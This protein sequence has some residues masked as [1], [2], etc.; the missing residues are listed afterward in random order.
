MRTRPTVSILLPFPG[1]VVILTC[2]LVKAFV[3]LGDPRN[4]RGTPVHA[5]SSTKDGVSFFSKSTNTRKSIKCDFFSY[6]SVC[7]LK[8]AA[9]TRLAL[10]GRTVMPTIPSVT[11]ESQLKLTSDMYQNILTTSLASSRAS[12]RSS[13]RTLLSQARARRRIANY[14]PETL[15]EKCQQ[16]SVGVICDRA[17]K[18]KGAIA[19]VEALEK[20]AQIGIS[21]CISSYADA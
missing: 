7:V 19:I 12:L 17:V 10:G 14:E 11:T 5:G 20:T 9:P 3:T 4:N 21:V 8:I 13:Y 6:S 1:G 2:Y 18:D 15:H 16:M